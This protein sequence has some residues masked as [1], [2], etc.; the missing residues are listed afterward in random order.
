LIK[1]LI[2]DDELL[3]RIGLKSTLDWH[4]H[5]FTLVGEARNAKEAE[6][7]FQKFSPDILL[8][9][10]SMPGVSGLELISRLR[11]LKPRLLSIILTHHEDFS[12]ARDALQLGALD[13]IL[14][15]NLTPERLLAVLEKARSLVPGRKE[16]AQDSQSGRPGMVSLDLLKSHL[17]K[18][19]SDPEAPADHLLVNSSSLIFE[20][21]QLASIHINL[22]INEKPYLSTRDR[23][24]IEEVSN[25]ILSS[26]SYT[27]LCVIQ[28]NMINYLFCFDQPLSPT[29]QEKTVSKLL[30]TLMTNLKKF[31]N[32]YLLA[33]VSL[34]A[35]KID[36]LGTMFVQAQSAGQKAFFKDSHIS[37]AESRHTRHPIREISIDQ[38]RIQSLIQERKGKELEDY[39]IEAFQSL[40]ESENFMLFKSF[41]DK[42]LEIFS[43]CLED[44]QFSRQYSGLNPSI[45]RSDNFEKLYDFESVKM[46]VLNI[47][48][49]FLESG[50][51]TSEPQM[52]FI[53]RK[54]I[55]YI[56]QNYSR[57]I[58]LSNLAT[59][60]EVS[61]N[62]LSFLF[63]QELGLNFSH[64][65]TETRIKHARRMLI[66]SNMKIYEIAERV[67]FD[68]PYYFSKV[69]KEVTGVTCRDYRNVHYEQ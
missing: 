68:S 51:R 2:V 25:Q 11:K 35:G 22:N 53:I 29:D 17:K 58:S 42:I 67:G 55:D 33:G 69:F 13:Y 44:D 57:N 39:F 62:Y 3:V 59:N 43:F 14:K 52:S 6:E 5:G 38:H 49:L 19:I 1:I 7:L 66:E 27:V 12:Y 64:Y 36:E 18:I 31:L 23:E 50:D 26:F 32:Y 28:A 37:F 21:Y 16:E 56:E 20:S 54:S 4:T 30:N 24:V 60:V 45:L 46:H 61:R 8:T 10:I 15:S 41:F 48:S 40:K 34:P 9:D 63:K 47:V 65:L